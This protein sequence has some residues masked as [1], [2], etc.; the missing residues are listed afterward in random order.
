MHIPRG[1]SHCFLKVEGLSR[2]LKKA[3]EPVWR[4]CKETALLRMV[5]NLPTEGAEQAVHRFLEAGGGSGLT[6]MCWARRPPTPGG[7]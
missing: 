4:E 1:E 7:N 5:A 2:Y 3:G 6:D